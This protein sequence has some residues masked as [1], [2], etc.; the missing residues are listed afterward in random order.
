MVMLLQSHSVNTSIACT[1][2]F[3]ATREIAV[4]IV[5]NAQYEQALRPSVQ[6][7]QVDVQY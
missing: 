1:T 6:I 7:C 2:Q 4:T 5:K 3:V